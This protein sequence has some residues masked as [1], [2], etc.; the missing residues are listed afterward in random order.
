MAFAE[1]RK[2]IPRT[3]IHI[4][5]G[6][7]LTCVGY[8]P[9]QPLNQVLLGVLL[10]LVLVMEAGRMVFPVVNRLARTLLGPFMRPKEEKSITGAPAFFGGVFLSFLLFSKPV[11]LAAM[12]PLLFGDRAGL[13]VGKGFGRTRIGTKTLE[14]SLACFAASLLAYVLLS[15]IWPGAFGFAPEVLVGA[16]LVGTLA[17]ALPRPFDDNLAIPLAVGVFLSLTA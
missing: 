13:L 1:V 9:A 7:F 4:L 5:G 8:L 2:E 6:V 3:L 16:S 12:V 17:E 15:S 11:A 14:G 10:S